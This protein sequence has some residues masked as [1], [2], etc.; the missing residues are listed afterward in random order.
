MKIR[1][2]LTTVGAVAMI[3]ALVLAAQ[4]QAGTSEH[5]SAARSCSAQGLRFTYLQAGVTFSVKVTQLR[6]T[7][8]TCGVSRP[9]AR[10]VAIDVLHNRKVPARISGL[11]VRVQYPC[12]G[13]SPDV[14]VTATGGRAG[15]GDRDDDDRAGAVPE[16]T[17]DVLGGA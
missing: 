17:F 12:A 8:L 13:C 5:A 1:S 2:G 3:V 7:A 6:T 9:L 16:V 11:R 4:A 14:R 10:Q 15:D